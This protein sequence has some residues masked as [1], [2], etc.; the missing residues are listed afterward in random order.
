MSDPVF[1]DRQIQFPVRAHFR[2]LCT[3]GT[4]PLEG[5][6]AAATALG[7]TEPLQE[8]NPSSGGRY[9][10]Y[11][12]SLLVQDA[13]RLREIDAAFRAVPGVKMVL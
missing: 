13:A 12:V 1:G 7:I 2:I 10:S 8:G 3:A 11:H 9:Q 4:A 5:L 6:R